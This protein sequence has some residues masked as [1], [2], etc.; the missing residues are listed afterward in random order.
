MGERRE[1]TMTAQGKAATLC[2]VV[3]SRNFTVRV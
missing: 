2:A 1:R 3:V